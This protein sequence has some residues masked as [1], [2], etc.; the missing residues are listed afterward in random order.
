MEPFIVSLASYPPRINAVH[1]CIESLLAQT[2]LPEKITLWLAKEEFP[3]GEDDLPLTLRSL[4]SP[5]FQI[6]WADV[7]LKPHNKYFWTMRSLPNV[8]VVTVDD[9]ILYE[10]TMLE[11]LLSCH[12]MFPNAIIGNRTHVMVVDEEGRLHSY[13]TWIKE[14]EILL[15]EPSMML[16]ATGVGGILYPPHVLPQETFDLEKI[17]ETTLEADDLW[18]KTMEI[19]AG[20]PTVAT[21]R[22]RVNYI[23]GTQDDGLWL[24][25]NRCGGN[26]KALSLLADQLALCGEDLVKGWAAVSLRL[27]DGFAKQRSRIGELSRENAAL[28]AE[29]D[30]TAASVRKLEGEVESLRKR[31]VREQEK[32]GGALRKKE[33]DI[34]R[35]EKETTL[36][37][38][39]ISRLRQSWSFKIGRVITRPFS[40]LRSAWK[41]LG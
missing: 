6:E 31:L 28:A 3:N 17:Q 30:R 12:H 1:R 11:D 40:I 14:Q 8:P 15:N 32:S 5:L 34:A 39:E 29:K 24:K 41:R 21:G 4:V 18:L 22:T 16:I 27:A 9:D 33:K 25:V 10:P 19:K 37:K 35:L 26:D 13:D 38:D 2:L 20:L 23:P 7:N 36:A